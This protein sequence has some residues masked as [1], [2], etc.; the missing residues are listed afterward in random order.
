MSWMKRDVF[1]LSLALFGSSTGRGDEPAAAIA[2]KA[3]VAKAVITPE[4]WQELT[5]VMGNKPTHKD[6]ELFARALVLNDGASDWRSSRTISIAS[7]WRRRCC[8]SVPR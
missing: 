1:S 4:K 5:N 2:M 3:G 6:H 7:T 8:G